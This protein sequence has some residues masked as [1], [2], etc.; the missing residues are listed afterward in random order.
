MATKLGRKEMPAGH[1][2]EDFEIVGRAAT[3]QSDFG[4]DVGVADCCCVNQF[5]DA[6]NAKYYHGSVVKSRKTS[7]WFV[8]LEWGRMF[9]GQSWTGGAFHGQDFMF[10]D[11]DGESDARSFFAKQLGSKNTKRIEEKKVGSATVW[12]ARGS[13]DG[14]LVQSLA[15]RQRGLPDAYKISS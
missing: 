2:A 4:S 14:Y 7:K 13:E 5:G 3:K 11:C 1:T 8:Y 12:A 9:T 10:V 6:N 15:T